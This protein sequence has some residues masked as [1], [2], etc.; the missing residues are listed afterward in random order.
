MVNCYMANAIIVTGG[1]GFIGSHIVDALIAMGHRVWV[2]DNLSTGRRE[3]INL[4]AKFIR[5]D[6][7]SPKLRALFLKIKPDFVFHL[8][9]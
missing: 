3:N 7:R 5:L 6:I 9:A 1:A 4:G 2:V 8:A